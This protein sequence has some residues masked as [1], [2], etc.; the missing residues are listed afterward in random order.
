MTFKSNAEE[1][2]YYMK[3]L[4]NTGKEYT[5]DEIKEYV[6]SKS[7]K[8]FSSGTYAGAMR[9]LIE[10][11]PNYFVPRRGIYAAKQ[12]S[13]SADSKTD[14]FTAIIQQALKAV[15]EACKVD[16][17]QL[18]LEEIEKIKTRSVE[19]KNTLNSLLSKQ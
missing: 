12:S 4:L 16:V 19:I 17:T 9:D 14:I 3:E 5:V 10:R 6:S 18:S 15:D 11:D 1:I 7:G 13:N 2:R 8:S